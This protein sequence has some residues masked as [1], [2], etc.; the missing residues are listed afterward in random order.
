[1]ELFS[2]MGAKRLKSLNDLFDKFNL[3]DLV[4]QKRIF[5]LQCLVIKES[6]I[7]VY[8]R[9]GREVRK[10]VPDIRQRLDKSLPEKTTVLGV[11]CQIEGNNYQFFAFDIL[12]HKGVDLS[13]RAW[14]E[15][16]LILKEVLK[17]DELIKIVPSFEM[18]DKNL[19]F[20]DEIII[21]SKH[22]SYFPHHKREVLGDWFILKS[23]S[24]K[25]HQDIIIAD[26]YQIG[27]EGRKKKYA[28]KCYQYKSNK[29]I[30]VG[31]LKIPN[32]AL[33]K[34][35]LKK[36]WA[37][38]R[39]IATVKFPDTVNRSRKSPWLEWVKY[40]SDKPFSSVRVLDELIFRVIIVVKRKSGERNVMTLN[41]FPSCGRDDV[42]SDFLNIS[43][44]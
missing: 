33:E 19:N 22:S 23:D 16:D 8:S 39:A 41:P 20:D 37:N 11:I 2:F 35:I 3:N 4:Y 38:K 14:S 18:F 9:L 44:V 17:E 36:V 25:N 27:V 29:M 42:E 7:K 12:E 31:R 1:M 40:R 21:K 34:K 10:D 13:R 24:Q 15:R 5:G 26:A 43:V 28:F 30:E 32:N 6:T